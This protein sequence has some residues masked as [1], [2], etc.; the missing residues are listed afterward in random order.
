[1]TVGPD[2]TE[3]T[4]GVA[5]GRQLVR[6]ANVI[7]GATTAWIVLF[8]SGGLL[9]TSASWIS[10]A[11]GSAA[12][13]ALTMIGLAGAGTG[14]VTYLVMQW[15]AAR[16]VRVNI[17]TFAGYPPTDIPDHCHIG[18]KRPAFHVA[19]IL[20]VAVASL[21]MMPIF[22]RHWVINEVICAIIVIHFAWSGPSALNLS[23][24]Y[25]DSSGVRLPLLGIH[26]PW[27]SVGSVR[28]GEVNR[29]A[30]KVTGSVTSTGKL[31]KR[32]TNRA[33]SRATPGHEFTVKTPNP[34]VAVWVARRYLTP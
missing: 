17:H 30:I 1:M 7:L 23:S 16:L 29:I 3:A 12:S 18:T 21:V 15:R 27:T 13:T 6:V 32:W 25:L 2:V 14:I 20:P 8:I 5:L 34:E 26:V 19:V 31:W 9:A 33:I 24:A 11:H 10:D 4:V 22:T 28:I